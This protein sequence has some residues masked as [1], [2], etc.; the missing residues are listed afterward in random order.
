MCSVF[1]I[2]RT[3][4][5]GWFFLRTPLCSVFVGSRTPNTSAGSRRTPGEPH[6]SLIDE[7]V[8]GLHAA[9]VAA[10]VT[11]PAADGV[12]ELTLDGTKVLVEP[13]RPPAPGSPAPVPARGPVG[14]VEVADRVPDWRRTELRERGWGWLD[15]R[16][17]LRI[18][19]PKVK[20]ELPFDAG[21]VGP[22]LRRSGDVRLEVALWALTHPGEKLAVRRV[23]RGIERS[24]AQ[25]STVVSAWVE[26]GL[27]DR[28]RIA[29]DAGLLWSLVDW[30]PRD[31]WIR[32]SDDDLRQANATE[33]AVDVSD[34]LAV[35]QGAQIGIGADTAAGHR[36]I[37]DPAAWKRLH[38]LVTGRDDH[39][40]STPPPPQPRHRCRPSPTR[41]LPHLGDEVHPIVIALRLAADGQRGREIVET[42][43]VEERLVGW[44]LDSGDR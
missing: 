23:A 12:W 10:Q 18:W 22:R 4:N 33:W 20:I 32:A 27:V 35:E 5:T 36:Y 1:G 25:V 39:S 38:R 16:G 24:Q 19:A 11:E 8:A 31:G 28:D 41:W 37:G 40:S 2:P 34:Q 43:G 6:A 21:S 29:D 3:P 17:H 44:K 9:G 26:D 15:R 42:W 13:I 14:V 7:I 30:W